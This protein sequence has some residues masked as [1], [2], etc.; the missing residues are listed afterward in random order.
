MKQPRKSPPKAITNR[1]APIGN[2]IIAQN[3]TAFIK[4][5]YIL[6]SVVAAHEVI[7]ATHGRKE[8]DL[9]FKIDYE[10]T[11]DRVSWEFL[12]SML[13]SRGFGSIFR[14]W[15]RSFLVTV[16]ILLLVKG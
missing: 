7:H 6:E 13:D 15:I 16:P 2:R 11:Y 14:G 5:R 4:G 12:D 9:V 10:K 3:Q 8:K 1:I